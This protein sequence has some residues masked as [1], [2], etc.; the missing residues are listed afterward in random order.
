[1]FLRISDG[2]EVTGKMT[3]RSYETL[4]PG[5][6]TGRFKLTPLATNHSLHNE[7]H[8]PPIPIQS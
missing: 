2:L 3:L 1:M 4:I 6:T 8:A 7:H 5:V